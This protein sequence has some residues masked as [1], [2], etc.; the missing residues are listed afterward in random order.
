[1]TESAKNI[2]IVFDDLGVRPEII[3]YSVA[4]AER[5][6][7]RITMLMLLS[8]D[9]DERPGRGRGAAAASGGRARAPVRSGERT[10]GG[11]VGRGE[12]VLAGAARE[13][14]K[15]GIAASF[16]VR[17][18]DPRSELLKFM[19]RQPT[20]H[21]TIWGGDERAL[22]GEAGHPGDGWAASVRHDLHRPIVM[23]TK[24]SRAKRSGPGGGKEKR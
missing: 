1:M 10:A 9:V 12:A 14:S 17:S 13:I 6:G 23:L 11:V 22:R 24:R 3:D 18:G 15:R 2:L 20:F 4:L 19:A 16:E 8:G 5:I 21:T 7:A